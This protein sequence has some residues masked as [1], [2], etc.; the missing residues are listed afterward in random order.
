MMLAIC[1]ATAGLALVVTFAVRR[2][3]SGRDMRFNWVTLTYGLL[4]TALGT[5]LPQRAAPLAPRAGITTDNE[6]ECRWQMLDR[7]HAVY[8]YIHMRLSIDDESARIRFA[9]EEASVRNGV[10]DRGTRPV[11]GLGDQALVTEFNDAFLGGRGG[12]HFATYHVSGASAV[13]RSHNVTTTV[14]W[15]GA[16]YPAGLN[17]SELRGTG[18]A[19]DQASDEAVA[20]VRHLISGLR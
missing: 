2:R 15:G 19:Y 13:A 16:E 12:G 14:Q 18:Y 1:I 20:I 6:R 11:N 10:T 8:L 9:D 5:A 4:A 3:R 7:D 17:G